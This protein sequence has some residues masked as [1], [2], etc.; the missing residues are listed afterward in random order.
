MILSLDDNPN[1]DNNH[2]T[3]LALHGM[4]AFGFG[5]VMGGIVMGFVIDKFGSKVA[6]IKNII[7]VI[8]MTVTTIIS[9]EVDEYNYM[10]FIMCFI[11]GYLDGAL[12]IHCLQIA[13]FQFVS[14]SEPFAV[15]NIMQGM[16]IFLT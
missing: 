15:F 9:I 1:L 12:N 13:G 8:I 2:R 3:A 6:S 4:I 10:T 11:W 14:K 16:T 7:L 5:E